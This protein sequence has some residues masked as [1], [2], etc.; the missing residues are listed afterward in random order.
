ME[1]TYRKND[2]S[3]LFSSV[4]TPD[5]MN[6]SDPQNYVPLYHKFFSLSDKNYDSINL[7]HVKYL[8]SVGTM[9]D[10]NVFECEVVNQNGSK[11]KKDVFFKY[12][13]LLD[14]VKYMMGKYDTK[15]ENIMKL[16]KFDTKNGH[17]K[18][19]D[20]NNAAYVDGFFTYLTSQLYHSHGFVHALDFYGSFLANKKDFRVNI[21]DDVEYLNDSEFFHLNR[22]SL[23]E[24]DNAYANGIFNFNTRKNKERLKLE[25]IEGDNVLELSNIEDL[26]ELD[27]IFIERN[28]EDD[29]EGVVE[30]ADLVFSFDIKEGDKKDEDSSSECSSRSSVTVGEGDEEESDEEDCSSESGFSTAS[31]DM[32]FATI[33]SFPVQVIALE[34]C[35]NTLDSLIVDHGDDMTDLEWGSMMIQVIMMLISYQKTYGLTHNDLHTNN[36][37]YVPTEKQFLYYRADGKHYKVP[38]FGRLY[39]I[40]DFGRAIYK[41]RGNVVCSDSYHPKGDAATQY[42]FEPYMN[43]DKPRLEPNFSFDLCRLGC[44]LLDFFLDELE[45]SPKDP[46]LAA[47]RVM[48]EWCVDDK[49]RN[50]LYKTDGE[51][52]YPNFKLY[53][54][55]ARTV[56]N[57]MPIDELRKGYFER[58]V[59]SK[60]KIGRNAKIMNIDDLPSYM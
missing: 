58:F 26:A 31:E 28:E 42:N 34:K 36:I 51:E 48:A 1:F 32:L 13:P 12:S 15:D 27:S 21:A 11:S 17:A 20:P 44:S 24:V 8:D 25:P 50:V 37:M 14:P 5:G 22:S 41:F 35:E 49:G 46:K 3:T 4:G 39:K 45:E 19:R 9:K 30:E 43:D 16:P 29:K 23:F 57:H 55:I 54:M 40:I 59:V 18:I 38:T 2:N 52:R 6:V 53:K 47:K 33:P 56:H 10:S 60:K 7:N